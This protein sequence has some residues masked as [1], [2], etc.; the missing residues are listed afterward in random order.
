VMT[1]TRFAS[2]ESRDSHTRGWARALEHFVRFSE[3]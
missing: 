1:H 2:V 3:E